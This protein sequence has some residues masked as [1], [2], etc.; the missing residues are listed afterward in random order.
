MELPTN[1]SVWPKLIFPNLKLLYIQGASATNE[2][3]A[4]TFTGC[5]NLETIQ[6]DAGTSLFGGQQRDTWN[7]TL[8][9]IAAMDRSF[10]TKG[11]FELP[12]LKHFSLEKQRVTGPFLFFSLQS[13]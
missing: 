12:N 9:E 6:V 3:L 1:Q 4:D 10:E 11:F 8:E 5:S 2:D 7:P 13:H